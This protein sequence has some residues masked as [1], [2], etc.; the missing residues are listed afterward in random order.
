MDPRL[1]RRSDPAD[2]SDRDPV[3]AFRT[4]LERIRFSPYFARLAAVTQVISPG[5]S[6]QIVHNRLTHSIKVTAVARAIAVRL[7]D[8]ADPDLLERLGGCD[9]VVVQ[10]AASA[11]D[12]GHPPFG[13]FG[14]RI[15]D[16]VARSRF[17]LADGFQGNAQTFRI[18]TELDVIGS[19]G[20]GLELTAA[21][22]AAVCKY[23]WSRFG[24]PDPHPSRASPAPKG[25]GP[26]PEGFGSGTFSAYV[27]DVG[28]MRQAL[29]AYPQIGPWRQTV[30]CSV[31]DLADDIAYSLH[32]LD[33]FHRAG[34]LQHAS[35]AAEFRTW[36]RSRS[37]LAAA[38]ADRLRDRERVPGHA[39][40]RLRRRLA[41]KD[42]W[43]FDDEAFAVAV[44]RVG[45]DLVDGLLA[46][47]FDSSLA[48]ERA[49]GAFTGSWIAHLQESVRLVAD[50][51]VRSGHV[52]LDRQAWH[53]VAVLKFVHQRFVLDRPDLAM[54]Q[55]GQGQLI[56]A[57][58][59][60]LDAWLADPADAARAPRRLIDLVA[61]AI[62]NYH[63]VYRDR[64]E[65]LRHA[66]GERSAG[67][68][69]LLR[70]GRGRGILDYVASLTDDRAAGTA[71]TLSGRGLRLWDAGT[72]L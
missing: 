46:V 9:P 28:E 10:A 24:E 18:L 71:A 21:V 29:S 51:P 48:A 45:T 60:E 41:A 72:A 52:Q 50:P 14:E 33:D 34:V 53:E 31:M 3:E 42:D 66:T 35:V 67:P 57:V 20:E 32:D 39:L 1:A 65:L 68:D 56:D 63:R 25:G 4:D 64:P 27:L 49:V 55:R 54:F 8:T 19:G 38:A 70:W 58:V 62:D 6:G 44:G 40:E 59:G 11:H 37:E 43:I 2:A 26:G 15:L 69:D 12:L 16:R 30:E 5:A 7:R 36:T 47:P 22:R 13:H 23:P 61:L 17:G